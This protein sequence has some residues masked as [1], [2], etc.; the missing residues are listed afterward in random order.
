M[1]MFKGKWF[2]AYHTKLLMSA[3]NNVA[4]MNINLS[5]RNYRSVNI[6]AV[7]VSADGK[8]GLITGTR[9][10]VTQLG[11]FNPYRAVSAATMGVMAGISTVEYQPETGQRAMK[12]TNINSG[13]WIALY[14]V[15][16]DSPGAKTFFCRVTPPADVGVIQIKLDSPD[17]KPVGYAVI[18][19][20][21]E[22]ITANLL[23]TITGV[24]DLVLI[25]Y[26]NGYDLE[27]WQFFH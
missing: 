26:G 20:G 1:F 12:V 8:I 11:T 21:H 23:S 15:N 7:T 27:E 19:P 25:F 3:L 14:G 16:F 10:G 9:D 6:D 2:V 5:E 24:H 22:E 18:N 4:G 13:D 17:G